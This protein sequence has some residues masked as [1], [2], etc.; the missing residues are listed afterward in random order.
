MARTMKAELQAVVFECLRELQ[1]Q[2]FELPD[3]PHEPAT[4]EGLTPAGEDDAITGA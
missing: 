4:A 2:G 1:A 3:Y